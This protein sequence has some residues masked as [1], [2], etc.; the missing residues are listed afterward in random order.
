[1]FLILIKH[2]QIL[3]NFN[4][5][6]NFK[7]RWCYWINLSNSLY[8]FFRLELRNCEIQMNNKIVIFDT[9][10]SQVFNQ[11]DKKSLSNIKISSHTS[12]YMRWYLF[13]SFLIIHHQDVVIYRKH[14]LSS[15]YLHQG[16]HLADISNQNINNHIQ[17]H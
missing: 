12:F 17:Q 9:Y 4:L 16:I 5:S 13:N 14:F 2:I 3:F 1:M 7:N 6:I 10:Q 8:V 11:L 15:E